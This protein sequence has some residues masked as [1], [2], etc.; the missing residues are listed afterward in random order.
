MNLDSPGESPRDDLS[1]PEPNDFAAIRSPSMQD[2]DAIDKTLLV[3][4]ILGAPDLTYSALYSSAGEFM[5][6]VIPTT[7][8]L[9]GIV[10]GLVYLAAHGTSEKALAVL[11]VVAAVNTWIKWAIAV[12]ILLYPLYKIW[13]AADQST[14][15]SHLFTKDGIQLVRRSGTPVLPWTTLSRVI[16]TSRGF[17]FYQGAKLA[18]FVPRRC[19][20]GDSEIAII[21]KF[22]AK[23]V[24]TTKLLA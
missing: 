4:T 3:E 17:L 24:S 7:I 6:Y 8:V 21:R 23:Y 16:E 10:V 11:G 14:I 5:I 19:L 12:A 2:D 1:A 9:A 20:Q 15:T 13:I 22:A 18:A